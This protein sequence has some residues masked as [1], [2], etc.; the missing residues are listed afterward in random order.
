MKQS[1]TRARG[2]LLAAAAVLL[3]LGAA[4]M[5]AALASAQTST[6]ANGTTTDTT[7]MGAYG[8]GWVTTAANAEAT[9]TAAGIPGSASGPANP[10]TIAAPAFPAPM[11][12]SVDQNG[13]ALVR[14]IVTANAG[15]SLTVQSWGGMW[16]IQSGG[17]GATTA[18]PGGPAGAHDFSAI[19]VGDFVGAEGT[20]SGTSGLALNASFVRDWTT[21]PML[22]GSMNGSASGGTQAETG[23]ASGIGSSTGSG[24]LDYTQYGLPADTQLYAGTIRDVDASAGTFTLTTDSG[25]TYT[26][27]S[28]PATTSLWDTGGRDVNFGDFQNGHAVRINATAGA[29]GSLNASVIR[30]TMLGGSASG[31][32]SPA[33]GTTGS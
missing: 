24:G 2:R 8:T 15:D 20:V 29:D 27:R 6:D 5:G 14:G 1:L 18:V 16:T 22:N 7:G 9:G 23:G 33:G 21:N 17:A 19:R 3:S 25:Q 11:V 31:S 28:D 32:T 12:V 13:D 4:G 30:D 10:V 26:V